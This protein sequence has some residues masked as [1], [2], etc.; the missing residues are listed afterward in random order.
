MSKDPT[1][2][3]QPLPSGLTLRGLRW[4]GERDHAP[5]LL[6][7]HGWLDNAASFTRLAPYLASHRD[8]FAV[9]LP[10]H[11]R[12]DH[13]ARSGVYHFLDWCVWLEE[14]LDEL[15]LKAPWSLLGHSM[16]A[17]IAMTLA[18]VSA[19]PI[20]QVVAIDGFAPS[21]TPAKLTAEQLKRGLKSRRRALD[22][23]PTR[24]ADAQ[25]AID[26]MER[27]RMPM[28]REAI[29]AIAR[30]HLVDEE[31][32]GAVRFGYDPMLQSASPLKL[33][34]EQV[35]A[36]LGAIRAPVYLVRARQGWPFDAEQINDLLSLM[37]A[38]V[39]VS[40]IEGG[41]HVHMDR[42]EA[43]FEALTAMGAF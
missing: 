20:A 38:P 33:T 26:R 37:A 32:G 4:R 5:P 17:A 29:E 7:V 42:A 8:V 35:G 28:S 43:V 27:A 25:E 19:H 12:S 15:A 34:G 2:W 9:D 39:K 14:L 11:G 16:G 10:G 41:H 36:L 18:G 30:R 22:R 13:P 31:P 40:E 6:A 3:S 1:P 24:L 21:V 23:A